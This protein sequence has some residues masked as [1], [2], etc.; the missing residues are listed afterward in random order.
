[1]SLLFAVNVAVPFVIVVLY[2]VLFT[3]NVSVSLFIGFWNSS[4]NFA[5]IVIVSPIVRLLSDWRVKFTFDFL[6]VTFWLMMFEW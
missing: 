5:V 1:M 2:S 3:M 6:I 4:N